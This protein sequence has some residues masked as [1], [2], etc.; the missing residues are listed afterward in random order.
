MACFPDPTHVWH[1]RLGGTRQHFWIILISQKNYRDWATLW[2]KLHDPKFNLFWLIH[3][4]DIQT[5]RRTDGRAI[6]CSATALCICCRA[7]KTE[8]FVQSRR[9]VLS[10]LKSLKVPCQKCLS[11]VMVI[12]RLIDL[13]VDWLIDWLGDWSSGLASRWWRDTPYRVECL[14]QLLHGSLQVQ[15]QADTALSWVQPCIRHR[16][17]DWP[18]STP[19]PQG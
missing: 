5:D 14:L 13:F 6:A 17:S 8:I 4:R 11:M 3:P 18:T 19:H 15:I 9:N 12:G 1:S 2:W 10:I 7:L 16:Y